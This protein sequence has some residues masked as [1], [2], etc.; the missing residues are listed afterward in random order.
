LKDRMKKA[1]EKLEF[2]EAAGLRDRI[3]ELEKKDILQPAF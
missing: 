3:T 1:A 2:E